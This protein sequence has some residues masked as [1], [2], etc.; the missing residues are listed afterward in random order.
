MA[1]YKFID[2]SDDAKKAME[3]QIVRVLDDVGIHLEG[4][5]AEE[6]END[7]RRIDT[8]LLRNSI[9]HAVSGQRPAKGEYKANKPR[10]KGGEIPHGSYNGVQGTTDEKAVYIGTNVEYAIYV[11]EGTSRMRPNRFLKNAVV[12]NEAQIRQFIDRELKG[13]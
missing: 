8:G 7:P 1:D 9:T 11:H 6:L 3:R 10:G 2:H 13:K 4:E 12:K 5:A